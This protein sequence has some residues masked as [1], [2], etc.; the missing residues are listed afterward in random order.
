MAVKKTSGPALDI[1]TL[2]RAAG[3]GKALKDF[4][5]D[6]AVAAHSAATTRD[7]LGAVDNVA[8]EPWPPMRARNSS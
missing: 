5:H 8:A 6:V 3:L 7:A 4:P 2:A 1:N